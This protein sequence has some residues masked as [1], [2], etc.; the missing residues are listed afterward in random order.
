MD[1]DSIIQVGGDVEKALKGQYVINPKQV[2]QEAWQKTTTTRWS[3]NIGL[4]FVLLIGMACSLLVGEYLGGVENIME[5]PEASLI[6][7]IVVTLVIW[8]FLAGVEMMG[9]L[10]AVGVK[11]QPKLVFAFL[12]RGSWVALCAVMTSVLISLGLQLLIIPGIFLAV[13]LSLTI[14]LVL[15]K[16][17]TPGKAIILSLKALRFQ[18]FNIF[19]VYLFMVMALAAS[20]LPMVIAQTEIMMFIASVIFI[21]SLSYLAPCYYNAKGILYREIF[22]MKLHAVAADAQVGDDTFVA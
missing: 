5:N 20:L 1:K 19:A 17:L 22:G 13:A 14:P 8:P 10:H 21:F 2:L 16:R 7:N 18:W 6:L 4:L 3:I 9:V 11:T 12:K 15:E